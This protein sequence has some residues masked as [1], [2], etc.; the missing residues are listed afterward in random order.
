MNLLTPSRLAPDFPRPLP[1]WA[2]R[3]KLRFFRALSLAGR[4]LDI[5]PGRSEK[6]GGPPVQPDGGIGSPG[7]AAGAHDFKGVGRN[8][9]GDGPERAGST[10]NVG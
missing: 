5:P 9:K 2:A 7:P 3:V 4:R 6:R 1:G 8:S 10:V